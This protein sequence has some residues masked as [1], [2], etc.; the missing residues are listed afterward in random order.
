[1]ISDRRLWT[2]LCLCITL[3]VYNSEWSDQAT[4]TV[5]IQCNNTCL[6]LRNTDRK[7]GWV[8]TCTIT[9]KIIRFDYYTTRHKLEYVLRKPS[10]CP[11][12][13]YTSHEIMPRDGEAEKC[14]VLQTRL[15]RNEGNLPPSI[16]RKEKHEE[17]SQWS[18][19]FWAKAGADKWW[20]GGTTDKRKAGHGR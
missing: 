20:R 18:G 14:W 4:C 10:Y 11:C 17:K 15:K 13:S 7:A 12:R 5:T 9:D 8:E 1:M 6:T 19:G 16:D 3:L 2:R